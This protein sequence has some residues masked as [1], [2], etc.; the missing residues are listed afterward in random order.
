MGMTVYADITAQPEYDKAFWAGMTDRVTDVTI[1]DKGR[2]HHDGTYK[3]PASS[4]DELIK[5][6]SRESVFRGISTVVNATSTGY[7]IDATDSDDLAVFVEEG[8]EIPI[9]NAV[10]DFT[11][12]SVDSH[13]LV[14][15]VKLDEDFVSDASF[16][17]EKYLIKRFGRCFGRA[18]D[19][20]FIAGTGVKEPTGILN[21]SEGAVVG[22]TTSGLTYDDVIALYFSA[23]SQYRKNGVWLMNDGTALALR[24]LKDKDGN[25]LWNQA[26]DTILGKPVMISEYM[27]DAIAGAKP[28]AFGDF[29]YYW[30]IIRKLVAMKMLKEVFT[31]NDQLG[32]L[33]TE[34]IDG[35]LIRRDAVK[36]LQ[37]AE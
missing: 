4:S 28:I 21:A 23:D 2:V 16:N 19:K 35:K 9:Y 22:A 1:L 15:F 24:R 27:P 10:E 36:V 32:Y 14:T 17:T 3:V 31:V 25:Y 12:I 26:N 8:G 18:E 29:S 20:A 7:R 13:K 6:I 37:I 34:Y 5:A 11:K 33:A 30:V